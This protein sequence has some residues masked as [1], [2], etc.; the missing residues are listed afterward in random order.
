MKHGHGHGHWAGPCWHTLRAT[1]AHSAG[2]SGYPRK[3]PIRGRAAATHW[4]PS[5]RSCCCQPIRLHCVLFHFYAAGGLLLPLHSRAGPHAGPRLSGELARLESTFRGT[6]AA[7]RSGLSC[8]SSL[9]PAAAAAAWAADPARA[10]DQAVDKCACMRPFAAGLGCVTGTSETRLLHSIP[11]DLCR[12]PHRRCRQATALSSGCI[13]TVPDASIAHPCSFF[14]VPPAGRQVAAA[15]GGGS[16]RRAAGGLACDGRNPGAP[17]GELLIARSCCKRPAGSSGPHCMFGVFCHS[18]GA[19][20]QSSHC[21][22]SAQMRRDCLARSCCF[23]IRFKDQP[24]KKPSEK[25]AAC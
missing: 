18:S 5:F 6:A 9:R 8:M 24:V 11:W 16:G 7:P 13:T 25:Q 22:A 4:L 15:V 20:V 3:P 12:A 10:P 21:R 1:Q 19:P 17:A 2:S 14:R 23:P